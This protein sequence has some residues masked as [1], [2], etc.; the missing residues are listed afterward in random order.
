MTQISDDDGA[1][2]AAPLPPSPALAVRPAALLLDF[3]GV[4][5][6]TRRQPDAMAQ[7]TRNVAAELARAG[8][9][10]TQEDLLPVLTGGRKALKDWKNASSRRWAPRELTHRE[11]W[12]D[13]YGTPLPPAAREVLTGSAGALQQMLTLTATRHTVRPGIR[14]LVD[15]ASGLGIPLGIVSNAHSGRAHRLIMERAGLTEAFGVQVYSDEVGVRKPNPEMIRIAATAL[16]T[17]PERC[18][19]V[20]DTYDRDVVAGRRANAAAVI[21][22]R[23]HHTDEVPFPIADTPDAIYDTPEGL[24][25]AL[26]TAAPAPVRGRAIAHQEVP[27]DDPA[28]SGTHDAVAE[29]PA[30]HAE[31]LPGDPGAEAPP[32]DPGPEAGFVSAT[33]AGRPSALLLDHGGVI[34]VSRTDDGLRQEFAGELAARLRRAGFEVTPE[35]AAAAITEIRAAHKAWKARRAGDTREIDATT[36]WVE[37]GGPVLAAAL[38]G[39]T[40]GGPADGRTGGGSADGSTARGDVVVPGSLRAWLRAEAHALMVAYA[41]AKSAPAVRAGVR[42]LLLA[43][44]EAGVPVAV[45]SNTVNGRAVREELDDAGL[46]PLIG[47]HVYSDELGRRKPDPLMPATALR[48]LGADPARAWFVGDKPSRDVLAARAAAVGHVVLVRGGTTPDAALDAPDDDAGRPDHIADD[49]THVAGLIGLA[50]TS[51][52]P[53][54]TAVPPAEPGTAAPS[55]PATPPSTGPSS[56]G[57]AADPVPGS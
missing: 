3:G 13:F 36:F 10:F 45:V 47:A 7:V 40:G 1:R 21:L 50:P 20:G 43:A 48:A 30:S 12:G 25:E 52:Q 53:A 54:A 14:E 28:S 17:T 29:A 34:S 16:G 55:S 32:R 57:R 26:R 56:G 2:G 35:Q 11:I 46:T 51:E 24:V 9:V 4:V 18:W 37:L 8:H 49:M 23:H 27:D 15:L 41:R 44:R 39:R 19:Y 6:E 33:R 22:T 42:E 31:A 38:D 5:F